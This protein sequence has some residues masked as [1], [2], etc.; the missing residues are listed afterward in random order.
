MEMS[1][2]NQQ[3][4]PRLTEI[5]GATGAPDVSAPQLQVV[6]KNPDEGSVATF[7]TPRLSKKKVSKVPV[8]AKKLVGVLPPL[9]LGEIHSCTSAPDSP[10]SLVKVFLQ[11]SGLTVKE[12]QRLLLKIDPRSVAAVP[13]LE[14]PR[15]DLLNEN[16]DCSLTPPF[17]LASSC[18]AFATSTSVPSQDTTNAGATTKC[19]TSFDAALLSSFGASVGIGAA[20]IRC[21]WPPQASVS[22]QFVPFVPPTAVKNLPSCYCLATERPV[23]P[24]ELRDYIKILVDS[25]A[26]LVTSAPCYALSDIPEVAAKEWAIARSAALAAAKPDGYVFETSFSNAQPMHGWTKEHAIRELWQNL[27]DGVAVAFGAGRLEPSFTRPCS[28]GG[29]PDAIGRVVLKLRGIVVG[30]VDASTPGVLTLRQRC[31][32]ICPRHLMLASAKGESAAG[33]HGEGFKV[34][35]NLLLRHGFRVTFT[36]DEQCWVFEHRAVHDAKVLNMVVVMSRTGEPRDDLLVTVSGPGAESLFKVSC[37]WDLLLASHMST[38]SDVTDSAL[39]VTSASA[40]PLCRDGSREELFIAAGR[41]SPL[42]GSVYS[43]CLFVNIDTELS[44]LGLTANLNIRLDRDRHTLPYDLPSYVGAAL[45]ATISR[46]GVSSPAAV[47]LCSHLIAK[48]SE[49]AHSRYALYMQET[50]RSFVAR[51]AGVEPAL[52]IFLSSNDGPRKSDLANLGFFVQTDAGSLADTYGVSQKVLKRVA[53]FEDWTAGLGECRFAF[54][55]RRAWLSSLLLALSNCLSSRPFK[56]FVKTFPVASEDAIHVQ[57]SYNDCYLSASC[58]TS[59]DGWRLAGQLIASQAIAFSTNATSSLRMQLAKLVTAFLVDPDVFNAADWHLSSPGVTPHVAPLSNSQTL[60]PLFA[61]TPTQESVK[62]DQLC[63]LANIRSRSIIK[64]VPVPVT[65]D[66]SASMTLPAVNTCS[67]FKPQSGC[68][69]P[70]VVFVSVCISVASVERNI[71]F[72]SGV[73]EEAATFDGLLESFPALIVR[74][75]FILARYVR[76]LCTP[77]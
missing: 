37:D 24:A 25:V 56:M 62:G 9:V 67:D 35:I 3:K 15:M 53:S 38:E 29:V 16:H 33:A 58:V 43:K 6:E 31:G 32:I 26:L 68:Y 52:V 64:V 47:D 70:R 5:C 28:A 51:G 8:L 20:E 55:R 48:F 76:S 46:S 63:T 74:F 17:A 75:D 36:M 10:I 50:L 73:M 54:F 60:Q 21:S 69:V 66:D 42:T 65:S 1:Y 30:E 57:F 11:S 41:L 4:V 45:D 61:I 12:L 2:S 59:V 18:T 7:L 72:D 27:R 40:I 49:S 13:T 77:C 39:A 23:V 44:T 22:L 14:H 34:A 71:L 19:S